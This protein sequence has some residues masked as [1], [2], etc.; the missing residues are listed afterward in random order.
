M[1]KVFPETLDFNV[2]IL[3]GKKDQGV[4]D[5]PRAYEQIN[6]S[7][8]ENIIS[9]KWAFVGRMGCEN[10]KQHPEMLAA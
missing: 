1:K 7:E 9:K 4:T 3:W 5:V 8:V 6:P 2:M 10:T